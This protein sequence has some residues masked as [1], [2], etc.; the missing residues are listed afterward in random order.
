MFYNTIIAWAVYYLYLSFS[1]VVPWKDC[2]NPWNTEC[3]FPLNQINDFNHSKNSISSFYNITEKG[4]LYRNTPNKLILFKSQ[5]ESA[6]FDDIK[7]ILNL[8]QVN[9]SNLTNVSAI[10]SAELN[11][12]T[13]WLQSYFVLSSYDQLVHVPFLALNDS[14]KEAIR[15]DADIAPKLID[16]HINSVL[17]NTNY[18]IV[19]NCSK[20]LSSPTQEFYF[21]YLT[22]MH[23]AKGLEHIG[24]IKFEIAL[25]LFFVF[26]TVY[27]ALWKGIKSAGKVP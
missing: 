15:F 22:E 16:T 23:R 24:G 17:A 7:T 9:T 2:N 25:S 27:F 18:T 19:M 4:L 11:S 3:C 10:L 8:S 21:R 5:Y 20:F 14:I 13:T 6:S 26:I 12:I 1:T